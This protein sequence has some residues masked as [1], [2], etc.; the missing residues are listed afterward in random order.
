MKKQAVHG[1]T[2][3]GLLALVFA[4]SWSLKTVHTW[5]THHAHREAPVCEAAHQGNTKHLHDERYHPDD[6][7][8]CAFIFSIPELP[9]LPD[10]AP[11]PAVAAGRVAVFQTAQ[12]A[13]V[14]VLSTCSRGPPAA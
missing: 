14:S 5:C 1:R 8:L 7:P 9:E 13:A 10:L 4:V 12:Y 11:T 3:A 2:H 6:C